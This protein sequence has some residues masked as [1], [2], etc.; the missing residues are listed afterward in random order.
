MRTTLIA[1]FFAV[2]LMLGT[3]CKTVSHEITTL[4]NDPAKLAS[5]S[6]SLSLVVR[7]GVLALL[8]RE[9]KATNYL[10]AAV[11]ALDAVTPEAILSLEDLEDVLSGF[12]TSREARLFAS[13][14]TAAYLIYGQD[15]VHGQTA[16]SKVA[17]AL[18]AATASGIRE[19]LKDD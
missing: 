6:N 7:S 10:H 16:N 5:V 19:A 18:L 11:L 12:N 2:V 1:F 13:F 17:T 3:G 8:D 9:P 4:E 15:Y 14:A